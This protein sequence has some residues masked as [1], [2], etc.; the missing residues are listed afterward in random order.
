M[1]LF[2]GETE[3]GERLEDA[4][5]SCDVTPD[6]NYPAGCGARGPGALCV[7]GLPSGRKSQWW[8][9]QTGC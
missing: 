6:T 4:K 1:K 2:K 5:E 7:G 8:G 3:Q 9:E